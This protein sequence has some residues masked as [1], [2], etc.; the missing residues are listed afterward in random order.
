MPICSFLTKLGGTPR[1]WYVSNK[2]EASLPAANSIKSP[3]G[4]LDAKEVMSSTAWEEESWEWMAHHAEEGVLCGMRIGFGDGFR[5]EDGGCG[6]L[7]R[8]NFGV[9]GMNEHG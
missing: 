8:L 6:F 2:T 7:G 1:G 5:V 9:G 4:C 3:P